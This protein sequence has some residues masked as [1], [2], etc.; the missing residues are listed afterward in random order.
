M[1]WWVLGHGQHVLHEL[2]PHLQHLQCRALRVGAAA[3]GGGGWALE[4]ALGE[5]RVGL[6]VLGA[7]AHQGEGHRGAGPAPGA[8]TQCLEP[9]RAGTVVCALSC[10]SLCAGSPSAGAL[11]V[12]PF[13][14]VDVATLG[15]EAC[16]ALLARA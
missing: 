4:I 2:Q 6:A 16:A 10:S 9:L 7:C 13:A 11:V 3:V 12:I 15:V 14:A 5:H 1:V 8:K